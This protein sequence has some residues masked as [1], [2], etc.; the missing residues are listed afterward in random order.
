MDGAASVIAVISLALSSSQVIY[1]AVSGFKNAP[2]AIQQMA[3]NLRS[4]SKVLQQLLGCSD[5]LY[6]A[7]E[8]PV[9]VKECAVNLKGFEEKLAKLTSPTNNSA[10][11]LWKNIRAM[12]QEKD[13]DRMSA[14]LQQHFSILSLQMQIIERYACALEVL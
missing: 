6:L 10:E 11:K 2:P 4:L 3:S 7:Q 14:L 8:L 12:L 13:L 9:L 5:S 1:K